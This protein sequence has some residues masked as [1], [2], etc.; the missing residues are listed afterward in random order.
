MQSKINRPW[1][2][3]KEDGPTEYNWSYWLNNY[4]WDGVLFSSSSSLYGVNSKDIYS[5]Y[6]GTN[7]II[8]DDEE[9]M[10][11]DADKLKIYN[12]TNWSISIGAPV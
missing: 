6:M 3:V 12:D 4:T 1:T 10:I 9:G 5:N 11:F 2:K 7:K 8:I